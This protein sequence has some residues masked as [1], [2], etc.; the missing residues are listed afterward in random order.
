MQTAV[1]VIMPVYNTRDYLAQAINS[2]L[3]QTLARKGQVELIVVDDGST[4]GSDE[5]LRSF[6][7]RI[8]LLSRQNAGQG[9][10]RNAAL[11]L[12]SGEFVYFMDSDDWIEADTLEACV[13]LCRKRNLDFTFFDA[14]TFFDDGDRDLSACPWFDYHRASF[15]T[16]PAPGVDILHDMLDRGIYRCSVC[17]CVFRKDFIEREGL[18]FPEGI[19]HEDELFAA[20]AYIKAGSIAG[21]PKDFYHRRM[22]AESVMTKPFSKRNYE[23]YMQTLASAEKIRLSAEEAMQKRQQSALKRLTEGWFLT[24]M[25]N[26]WNLPLRCRLHIAFLL[27]FRYPFTFHLRTF[28][29]LLIKKYYLCRLLT[30]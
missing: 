28:I 24:L 19:L 25:H 1:T 15:Y 27:L 8:K 7:D 2:V 9:A 13:E 14:T 29:S 16:Q 12:A 26:G 18:R 10:A 20:E 17:M 30:N 11:K 5:V 3:D 21:I 23:G 6:S 22:R 4:D